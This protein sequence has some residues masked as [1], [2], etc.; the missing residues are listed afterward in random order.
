M[1]IRHPKLWQ[2]INSDQEKVPVS[3][4]YPVL[5][6]IAAVESDFSFS[7]SLSPVERE[8]HVLRTGASFAVGEFR[9]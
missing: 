7:P 1:T 8:V 5:S 4:R 9:R 2:N 3:R 6:D